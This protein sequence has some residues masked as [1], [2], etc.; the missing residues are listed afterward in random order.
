[1]TYGRQGCRR[2]T[3]GNATASGGR[4]RSDRL[5]RSAAGPEGNARSSVLVVARVGAAAHDRGRGVRRG[6]IARERVLLSPSHARRLG[7]SAGLGVVGW[8]WLGTWGLGGGV[9]VPGSG[10]D[11]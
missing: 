10:L 4:G 6:A 8:I 3:G 5:R 7:R 9:E 2:P 11:D 1:M